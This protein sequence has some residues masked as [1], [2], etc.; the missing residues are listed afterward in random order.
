M[1]ADPAEPGP[2]QLEMPLGLNHQTANHS[3]EQ[4]VDR[5][6]QHL[7]HRQ[8][9]RG[10]FSENCRRNRLS[11]NGSDQPSVPMVSHSGTVN[12]TVG[13]LALVSRRLS[14]NRSKYFSSAIR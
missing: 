6:R 12:A 4:S 3:E 13:K 10:S 5:G 1:I 11:G 2:P 8:G 14:R 7:I 9:A